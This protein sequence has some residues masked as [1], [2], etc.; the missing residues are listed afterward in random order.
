MVA[1]IIVIFFSTGQCNLFMSEVY[2]MQL[3]YSSFPQTVFPEE[4][5]IAAA[6]AR[7]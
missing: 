6:I 3:T 5:T 1:N 4:E 2:D 7:D